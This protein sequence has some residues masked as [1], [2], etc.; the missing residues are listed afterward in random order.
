MSAANRGAILR[1]LLETPGLSRAELAAR[2]DVHVAT[3]SRAVIQLAEAGLVRTAT[4]PHAA[5]GRPKDLLYVA[6]DAGYVI[7]VDIADFHTETAIVSLTG[8]LTDRVRHEAGHLPRSQRLDHALEVIDAAVRS[9][10]TRRLMGIGV[11]VPGPVYA[12]GTVDFAPALDW[13]AVPLGQLLR[14]AHGMPTAVGNDAN[15]IALAESH[16]GDA[17]DAQALIAI[18]VFTGIGS[19]LVFKGQLWDGAHGAS[20]QVGRMLLSGEASRQAFPGFGDLERH[21]GGEGIERRALAAGI[22]LDPRGNVFEELF[23]RADS[24]GA[25]AL[26]DE[27]LAE[28]AMMLINVCALMDPDAIVFAGAFTQ[29][30][31]FVVPELTARIEGKVLHTPRLLTESTAGTLLG[32]AVIAQAAFGPLERLL[33]R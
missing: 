19:G 27:V 32:A 16:F 30:A 15:L 1:A 6:P 29:I 10:G 13:R 2:T 5:R 18:A 20:G 4:S 17:R 23:L 11:S 12:D 8:E 26:A 21:L 28:Y 7:A 9:A 14:D 3:V 24:P 31:D 33:D 22:R 25:K